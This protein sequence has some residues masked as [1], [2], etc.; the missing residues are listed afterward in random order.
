MIAKTLKKWK[1]DALEI[2]HNYHN[3]ETI[4]GKLIRV[5]A[6]RIMLLIDA[7]EE[8]G[9]VVRRCNPLADTM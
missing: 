2:R 9:G 4:D 3:I 7:I 8:K 6:S 5:Q 1:R